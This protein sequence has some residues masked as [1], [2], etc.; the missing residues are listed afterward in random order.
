MS[1]Y[2]FKTKVLPLIARVKLTYRT[3]FFIQRIQHS[4]LIISFNFD[5]Y[6]VILEFLTVK[7]KI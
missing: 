7:I 3:L 2:S 5:I 1:C 4:K 6:D